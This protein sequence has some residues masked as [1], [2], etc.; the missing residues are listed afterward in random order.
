MV[1]SL[2]TIPDAPTADLMKEFYQQ[3]QRNPDKAQA[4]RQAMLMMLKT[5]PEPKQWAG[6]TLIGEP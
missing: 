1:V 2:W 4:L 6:F 3:L 5:H